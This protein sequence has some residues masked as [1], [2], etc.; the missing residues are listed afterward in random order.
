MHKNFVQHNLD[1]IIFIEL[2]DD[3]FSDPDKNRN[4]SHSTPLVAGFA[5]GILAKDKNLTAEQLKTKIMEQTEW[6]E[7]Y[8]RDWR[9][10]KVNGVW[11]E[12][13]YKEKK[14]VRI[15]SLSKWKK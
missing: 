3:F 4:T 1:D 13:R 5:A 6:K 11:K 12:E 8:I 10:E 7:I 9:M 2:P 15:L 14:R